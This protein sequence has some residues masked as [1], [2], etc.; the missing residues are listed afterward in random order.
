VQ[1]LRKD[2]DL[3]TRVDR[4][5]CARLSGKSNQSANDVLDVVTYL[6]T[7]VICNYNERNRVVF[8]SVVL[9]LAYNN[10]LLNSI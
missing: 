4:G 7:S 2:P 5:A 6:V 1:F 9:D 8:G 3:L 10:T